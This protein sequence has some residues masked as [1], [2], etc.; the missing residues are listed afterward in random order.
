MNTCILAG[1]MVCIAGISHHHCDSS[2]DSTES[3]NLQA[4]AT[5]RSIYLSGSMVK[6]GTRSRWKVREKTGKQ[7]PARTRDVLTHGHPQPG[8]CQD[9][10]AM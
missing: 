3:P 1:H 5:G 4:R 7:L 2:Q 10:T 6:L 9:G 8:R